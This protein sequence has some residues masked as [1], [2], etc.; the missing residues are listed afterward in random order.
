MSPLCHCSFFKKNLFHVY[1][2]ER[3]F[4]QSSDVDRLAIVQ[5]SKLKFGKVNKELPFPAV[6]SSLVMVTLSQL[7]LGFLLRQAMEWV[8][9]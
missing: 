9:S 5:L 8:F 7:G 3:A 4:C 1:E 6:L 2:Q